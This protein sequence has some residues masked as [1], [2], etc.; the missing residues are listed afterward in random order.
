MEEK[1]RYIYHPYFDK[2]VLDN[3][4]NKIID[5]IETLNQQD[6]HIKEL[7]EIHKH[8]MSGKY[9]PANIAEKFLKLSEQSQRQLVINE[10][11]KLKDFFLEEPCLHRDEEMGTEFLITKDTSSIADYVLDRIKELKGEEKW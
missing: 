7:E 3:E 11:E 8:I 10:F 4:T 6:K 2:R 5:T 1:E 9:V